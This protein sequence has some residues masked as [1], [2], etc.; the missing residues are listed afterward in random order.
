M[1]GP[2]NDSLLSMC[3]CVCWHVC[4]SRSGAAKR[5]HDR[6]IWQ[7]RSCRDIWQVPIWKT[8]FFPTKTATIIFK[9]PKEPEGLRMVTGVKG[10]VRFWCHITFIGSVNNYVHGQWK[11]PTRVVWQNV[12]VHAC[13]CLC[14]F[15][16]LG[17][18]QP[19]VS[20]VDGLLLTCVLTC[21]DICLV[22]IRKTGR[23]SQG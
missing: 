2:H 8:A 14:M 17:V 1:K 16:Y 19:N 21:E 9:K 18:N 4:I 20:T 15:V 12:C 7:F 6:N 3:V 11:V 10:Q 13:M 23:S 5:L 22:L